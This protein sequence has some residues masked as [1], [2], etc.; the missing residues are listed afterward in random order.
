MLCV[1]SA[2][3]GHIT[4]KNFYF[5]LFTLLDLYECLLNFIPRKEIKIVH[6]IIKNYSFESL[7][8]IKKYV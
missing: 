5:I 2:Y 7:L 3:L 8:V 4:L 6:I 1:T